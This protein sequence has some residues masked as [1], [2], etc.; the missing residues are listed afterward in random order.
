MKGG[1]ARG[2]ER[3]V[4]SVFKDG[5]WRCRGDE[6]GTEWVMVRGSEHSGPE[7]GVRSKFVQTPIISR[8]LSSTSSISS[9]V[10]P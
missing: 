5:S 8:T 4:E 1:G 9:D 7:A 6:A 3:V 2:R 10:I